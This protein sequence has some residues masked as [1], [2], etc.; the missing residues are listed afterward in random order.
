MRTLKY[1]KQ[2][3]RLNKIK[4][5]NSEKNVSAL[6][7][8]SE[9]PIYIYIREP[10]QWAPRQWRRDTVHRDKGHRHNHRP[11]HRS[12]HHLGREQLPKFPAST[13]ATST[14]ER[15]F[16]RTFHRGGSRVGRYLSTDHQ[17]RSAFCRVFN[18]QKL[19]L[20]PNPPP[21]RRTPLLE[22]GA[23]S[24]TTASTSEASS[25]SQPPRR[26]T[27]SCCATVNGGLRGGGSG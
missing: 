17:H 8:K 13:L 7:K 20:S 4:H 23:A 24:K 25:C 9:T 18:S 10:R 14:S 6:A 21:D 2:K 12:R 27:S 1:Q 16:I 22:R 11:S 26:R 19:P 3:I 5:K 15:S